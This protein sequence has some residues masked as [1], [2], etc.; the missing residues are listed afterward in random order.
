MYHAGDQINE[1]LRKSV[2]KLKYIRIKKHI[3]VK[4]INPSLH[5][6]SNIIIYLVSGKTARSTTFCSDDLA[7]VSGL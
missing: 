3:V 2:Y 4:P 1:K 5:S 6:E 7:S